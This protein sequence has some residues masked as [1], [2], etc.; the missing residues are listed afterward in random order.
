MATNDFQTG[1]MGFRPVGKKD[2]KGE[3][4]NDGIEK[5]VASVYP[6]MGNRPWTFKG[7]ETKGR[8]G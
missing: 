1:R 5:G 8:K 6:K 3:L 7:T 2:K 4:P